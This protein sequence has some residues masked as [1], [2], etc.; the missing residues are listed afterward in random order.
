M[1]LKLETRFDTIK[2]TAVTAITLDMFCPYI[3]CRKGLKTEVL[4]TKQNFIIDY[5]VSRIFLNIGRLI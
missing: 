5:L 3:W 1:Y 4:L 2:I